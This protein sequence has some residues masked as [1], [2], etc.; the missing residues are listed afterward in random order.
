MLDTDNDFERIIDS[1]D[2]LI[3]LFRELPEKNIGFAFTGKKYPI[4]VHV[5]RHGDK[6]T[7]REMEYVLTT[8]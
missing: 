7:V 5:I 3:A 2:E 1:E 8:E 4:L 6:A